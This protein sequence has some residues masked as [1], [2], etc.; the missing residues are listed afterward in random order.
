MKRIYISVGID[1]RDRADICS[2]I[3]KAEE[4]ITKSIKKRRFQ[5]EDL[6]VVDSLVCRGECV[7]FSKF[8]IFYF[9]PGWDKYPECRRDKFIADKNGIEM[10]FG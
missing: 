5:R 2:D 8:D 9:V 3:D 7:D 6:T 1:G 4:W 10:I